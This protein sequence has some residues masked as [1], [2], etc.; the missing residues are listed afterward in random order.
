MSAQRPDFTTHDVATEIPAALTRNVPVRVLAVDAGGALLESRTPLSPGTTG[1]VHVRIDG[2]G[3]GES[4]R[5]TRCV[6]LQGAGT[7]YHAGVEFI[8]D[9]PAGPQSLRVVLRAAIVAAAVFA[10]EENPPAVNF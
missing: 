9:E 3:Y 1:R 6:L 8:G 7:V 4:A 5:V 10:G 2:Q